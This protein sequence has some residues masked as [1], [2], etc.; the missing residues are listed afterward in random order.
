M[1]TEVIQFL[2]KEIDLKHIPG[3][4]IHIS[5]GGKQLLQEAIGDR[6]VYPIQ[7]PMQL[8]TVFDLASLTKVIATLPA[9]LKLLDDGK[10]R[11]DDPVANFLPQFAGTNKKQVTL[12]HLLTHTSGLTAHRQFYKENL[13]KKEM[14]QQIFTAPLEGP[15]GEQVAYSDLG[16][17]LLYQIIEK[18]TGE[19]FD[20]FLAKHF[21]EPLGMTDTGFKPTF[22]KTRFAVT[23]Y[24]EQIGRYKTGIVH[25]ENTEAMGGV[26]GH[27]GLF[28]TVSDIKK[29]A[30]MIEND[31]VFEGEHILSP[32]SLKLARRNYT[33]FD[34]EARG[35]GW[36][37][38]SET[39]ASCGDYFSSDSYGHTG[40]TGTSIWFDPTIQLHVILLTNRVHFGRHPH[41]IR[42]RP[43]LH[44]LIRRFF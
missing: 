35:I 28:S 3:A 27:A 40:F 16:F 42:L 31:G 15:V 33:S 17:M 2:K 6:S 39:R 23:E 8:D 37:M 36:M 22:S 26:S 5:Q 18:V 7:Q 19:D 24:S 41:M 14:F 21:Y 34:E 44:N 13:S 29:F 30:S 43:R 10:V 11:L 4:V 32:A 12:R 25:D 9:I 38:K 20:Q 1:R